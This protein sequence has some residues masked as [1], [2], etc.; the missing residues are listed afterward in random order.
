MPPGNFP[1]SFALQFIVIHT[2]VF[3]FT[4]LPQAIR[5]DIDYLG[6][7]YPPLDDETLPSPKQMG[8]NNNDPYDPAAPSSLTVDPFSSGAAGL[9]SNMPRVKVTSSVTTRY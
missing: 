3:T 8:N 4:L 7:V 1:L 9:M 6:D 2:H 5:L